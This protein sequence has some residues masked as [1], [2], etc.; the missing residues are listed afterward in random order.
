M[1]NR[2]RGRR[3]RPQNNNQPPPVFDPQA[4]REAISVVVA[5]IVQASAVAATT[6]QTSA[7]VGQG[8]TSNRQHT[9]HPGHGC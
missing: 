7:T 8:G 2:G 9:K 4:F 3:G 6:A 1:E 5:I